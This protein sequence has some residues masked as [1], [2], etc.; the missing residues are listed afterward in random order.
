MPSKDTLRNVGAAV[1]GAATA[2]TACGPAVPPI[3]E[4]QAAA[5]EKD[6]SKATVTL[7]PGFI[8]EEATR[9]VI[10]P[11]TPTP[12][13]VEVSPLPTATKVVEPT[14]T[15][16]AEATPTKGPEPTATATQESTPIPEVK[17]A[18]N[19]QSFSD[20]IPD[21]GIQPLADEVKEKELSALEAYLK[22]TATRGDLPTSLTAYGMKVTGG[23]YDGQTWIF[24]EGQGKQYWFWFDGRAWKLDGKTLPRASYDLTG[25]DFG[26][27]DAKGNIAV[28]NN[29][30]WESPTLEQLGIT[31]V[32]GTGT[33]PVVE[34]PTTTPSKP[35]VP[36]GAIRF[37]GYTGWTE[38]EG[39]EAELGTVSGKLPAYHDPYIHEGKDTVLNFNGAFM[40][41]R[42]EMVE[43]RSNK[44]ILLTVDGGSKGIFNVL[45]PNGSTGIYLYNQR[46]YERDPNCPTD[47]NRYREVCQPFPV[48]VGENKVSIENPES[49][50]I[51]GKNIRVD[52]VDSARVQ[53]GVELTTYTVLTSGGQF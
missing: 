35:E 6:T 20:L 43:V 33:A 10:V 39:G 18:I 53:P 38:Y 36:A 1:I 22:D 49:V 3:G 50:F 16:V 41:V 48:K 15:K 47:P 32:V 4:L 5:Q 9:V 23:V 37:P 44:D 51:A 34:K 17:V 2:L 45:V 42:I 40:K 13:P 7:Y 14:A 27:K 25:K 19:Y 8:T 11:P 46:F 31:A 12:V 29:G 28:L 52:V 30:N 21:R 26:I 24:L